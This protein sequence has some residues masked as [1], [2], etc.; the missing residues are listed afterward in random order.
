M[1]KKQKLSYE[2]EQVIREVLNILRG[3]I[4][5]E[6]DYLNAPFK[7]INKLFLVGYIHE[8]SIAKLTMGP[9][10]HYVTF[11]HYGEGGFREDVPNG[12]VYATISLEYGRAQGLTLSFSKNEKNKLKLDSN[13][14]EL[15]SH[16]RD[17]RKYFTS[18]RGH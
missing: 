17:V 9:G 7:E 11:G 18:I 8:P 4:F 3:A 5:P 10:E 6:Y 12:K 14:E 2:E 1:N 16:V 13:L 15:A